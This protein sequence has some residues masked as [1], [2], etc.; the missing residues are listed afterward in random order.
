M[1][2]QGAILSFNPTPTLDFGSVRLT[3]SLT[4]TYAVIND[5]NLAA[6]VTLTKSGP[7]FAIAPNPTLTTVNAGSSTTLNA[8]FN[9]TSSGAQNGNIAITTTAKRCAPLPPALKLTGTGF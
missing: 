1:T 5:G 4:K 8:T 2:A 6:P 7:Q 9:P 3:K